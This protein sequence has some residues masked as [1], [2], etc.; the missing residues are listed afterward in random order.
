VAEPTYRWFCTYCEASDLMESPEMA[1]LAIDVHVSVLHAQP[2][3]A[4]M[5]QGEQ[6]GRIL[7]EQGGGRG[8]GAPRAGRPRRELPP[9]DRPPEPPPSGARLVLSWWRA[10][11]RRGGRKP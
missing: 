3:E 7:V 6:D 5:A 11:L 4:I 8:Q 2:R 9:D 10:A 1:R